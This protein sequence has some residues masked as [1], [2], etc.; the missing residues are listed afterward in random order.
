MFSFSPVN[1][2]LYNFDVL[3]MNGFGAVRKQKIFTKL[4]FMRSKTQ[5]NI[6]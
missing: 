2:L 1:Q 4:Y 5:R 6:H 3:I